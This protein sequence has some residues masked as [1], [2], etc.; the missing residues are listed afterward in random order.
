MKPEKGKQM[1]QR[2]LLFE[3]R[4]LELSPADSPFW[5]TSG[6]FGP[7]YIN[8]HYLMGGEE[9]A[10]EALVLLDDPSPDNLVAFYRIVKDHLQNDEAYAELMS[11]LAEDY[12]DYA[13]ISGGA[14]R[15][16]FFSFAIAEI[17]AKPHLALLKEGRSFLLQDESCAEIPA[18]QILEGPVLHVADLLT[19][20]SSYIRAWIPMLKKHGLDLK[21]T[22]IMVNRD[23]EGTEILRQAGVQVHAP[24]TLDGAFFK[25]AQEEGYLSD[26]Q[27]SRIL[28][29]WRDPELYMHSF[30]KDHPDFIDQALSSDAKTKERAERFISQR[31]DKDR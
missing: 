15:D 2:K 21:E 12:H 3:R 7:Y 20:G 11:S 17:L 25:Q 14:R 6:T 27:L 23:Q 22:L 4:A 28:E 13:V 1:Q 24:L 30:I 26:H 16:F 18:D 9:V 10:K 19:A 29:F 8:T 31:K 5:Y